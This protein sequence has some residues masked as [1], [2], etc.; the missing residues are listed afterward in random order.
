MTFLWGTPE[1]CFDSLSG[2][3]FEPHYVEVDGYRVH[4][5]DEGPHGATPILLMHGE[6]SWCY[7]YRKNV[8][9]INTPGGKL[10]TNSSDR[11]HGMALTLVHGRVQY[12]R[13]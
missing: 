10:G 3:P 11:Q 13:T 2:F 4:Y 5:A 6:P 7:L 1:E 9:R 8:R 12:R